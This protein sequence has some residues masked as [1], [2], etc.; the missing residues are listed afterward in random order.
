M[1]APSVTLRREIVRLLKQTGLLPGPGGDSDRE[2]LLQPLQ[3]DGSA[4]RFFRVFCDD[5][6][7]CLAVLPAGTAERDFAE[8]HAAAAIAE[9]LGRVDVPVPQ[10]LGVNAQRG[11]LLFEDLGDCRLHDLLQRN[12]DEALAWYPDIVRQLARMQVNG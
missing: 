9:H 12:R 1:K 8:A 2:P 10:M 11:I 4:R 3:A 7:L 5:R 6:P